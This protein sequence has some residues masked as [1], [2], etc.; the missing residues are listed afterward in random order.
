MATFLFHNIF[1]SR[2]INN[3]LKSS[4]ICRILVVQYKYYL[5]HKN[6]L[7][8]LLYSID[9][10]LNLRYDKFDSILAIEWCGEKMEINYYDNAENYGEDEELVMKIQANDETA[11]ETL[12]DKY[13]SVI[14]A[15]V[16]K[17]SVL[18][19]SEDLV[20]EGLLGLWS[21][22]QTYNFNG[23]ASFK[24]Y[25]YKCIDNRINTGANKGKGK[26]HI[27]TELLI[28][29]D[30]DEST[31]LKDKSTP[32]QRIIERENYITTIN[33]IKNLLSV[34]EFKVLS[35]YLAG[36]SYKQIADLLDTNVKAIDN[37]I[38]RI[39]KKLKG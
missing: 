30:S 36:N 3:K 18:V 11:F 2:L 21:A 24:T 32:E 7:F 9:Y 23:V 34:K 5:I 14:K 19:D 20:Q 16:Q 25:A 8:F 6:F 10:L 33:R 22:A 38:Q 4:I 13:L 17:Y 39:R 15:K 37:A 28:Y 26:K 29:L 12:A 27:P 35:Y 1:Y 31:Q